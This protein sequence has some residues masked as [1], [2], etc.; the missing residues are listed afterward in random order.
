[1]ALPTSGPLSINDIAVEFGGSVPHSL[2]EYY[3]VAAGIPASGTI[4]IDDFYGKSSNLT[5]PIDFYH[6]GYGNHMGTVQVYIVNSSGNIITPISGGGASGLV[7]QISGQFS[8]SSLQSF[9]RVQASPVISPQNYRILWVY[10]STGGI[11]G[12]YAIR[13]AVVDGTTYDFASNATGWL[14]TTI[15]SITD[16]ATAFANASAVQTGQAVGKWNRR[17]GST[18]TS[19]TGPTTGSGVYYVYAEVSSSKNGTFWLYSPL[20]TV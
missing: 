3:G 12:D 11:R 5:I 15:P 2:S 4:A 19:G 16:A 14:T 18:P 13:D 1:M 10:Q 17:T 8:V 6:H 20:V 9:D 7:Y